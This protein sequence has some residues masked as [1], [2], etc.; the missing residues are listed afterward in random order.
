MAVRSVLFLG[1]FFAAAFPARASSS[2][3]RGNVKITIFHTNDIHGW[4]QARP[5]GISA[6][7]PEDA[8]DRRIGGMAALASV[9]RGE[10]GPKLLLDS[11]DWFQGT[12]EGTLT[13]GDA[14]VDCMN[15]LGYDAIAPG[16][17]DFDL[18]KDNLRR[19]VRAFRA[20]VLGANVY[21]GRRRYLKPYLI[22]TVAGVRVGIFGLLTTR[23]R[24]LSFA[25][26]IAGLSFRREVDEARDAV[27][28]LRKRGATVIIALT[29]VGLETPERA[30]FEG[31]RF[32][33]SE[34]PGIDMILGGHTHYRHT[35]LIAGSKGWLAQ[36]GSYLT[37]VGKVVIEVDPS[38]RRVIRSTGTLIPLWVDDVGEAGEVAAIVKRHEEWVGRAVEVVVGTATQTLVT[39]RTAESALGDWMTDCTREWAETQIAFQNSGGIRANLPAGP[40]TLRRLFQIMPFDNAVVTLRL[41]GADLLRLLERGVS[42]GAGMIQVSGLRFSYEPSASFGNRVRTVKVAEAPLIS[43]ATYTLAAPDFLVQGGDGYTAFSAGTNA[44]N[45]GMLI[46][47]VLAWCATQHSP[48]QVPLGRRINKE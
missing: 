16:N 27:G 37:H 24:Q 20:P 6:R 36:A 22:K 30:P 28:E 9:V 13:R 46:R 47:D 41:A 15:A 35:E 45:T 39:S 2:P 44:E 12:P 11:G 31:D 14:V 18:G 17:H 34:V 1:V 38:T 26:N 33:A 3:D 32:L 8:G 21:E 5:V 42:G 43:S 4:I 25:K 7:G 40:I 19:L 48:V 10:T 29:H 23:M